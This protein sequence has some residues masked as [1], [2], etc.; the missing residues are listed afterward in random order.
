MQPKNSTSQPSSHVRTTVRLPL[1]V[2]LIPGAGLTPGDLGQAHSQPDADAREASPALQNRLASSPDSD[3]E[4]DFFETPNFF[5]PLLQSLHSELMTLRP[6]LAAR[7][8]DI[9]E[10]FRALE[11]AK[12]E[13]SAI[14]KS[15]SNIVDLLNL[16]IGLSLF[17]HYLEEALHATDPDMR[18]DPASLSLPQIHAMCRGLA[19]CAPS[20]GSLLGQSLDLKKE[21]ACLQGLTDTL[22]FQA[23]VLGLP[24]AAPANGLLLDILGWVGRG[25]QKGLLEPSHAITGCFELSLVLLEEWTGEDACRQL[26]TDHN[27]GRCAAT[28]ATIARYNAM[29]LD[30]VV[31]PGLSDSRELSNR[32]RLQHC[33]LNLCAKEVL[34]PPSASTIDAQSVLPVCRTIK[35]MLDRSLLP[36][37]HPAVLKKLNRLLKHIGN[38][39]DHALLGP[40]RDCTT[41]LSFCNFLRVLGHHR[42]GG[43]LVFR[44]ALPMQDFA[45]TRLIGCING[46][47]FEKTGRPSQTLAGLLGF[48]QFCDQRHAYHS[49]NQKTAVTTAGTTRST[50]SSATVPLGYAELE[51]ATSRLMEDLIAKG[52][53]YFDTTKAIGG[54]LLRLAYLSENIFL[55]ASAANRK[56]IAALIA[57]INETRPGAWSDSAKTVVLNA[58]QALLKMKIVRF[59]DVLPALVYLLPRATRGA[60]GKTTIEL[61]RDIPQLSAVEAALAEAME[62]AVDA[63]AAELSEFGVDFGMGEGMQFRLNEAADN[64]EDEAMEEAT[65]ILKSAP[66]TRTWPMPDLL[67]LNDASRGGTTIPV[68]TVIKRPPEQTTPMPTPMPAFPAALAASRSGPTS[69]SHASST[70]NA[71]MPTTH[72]ELDKASTA[73]RTPPSTMPSVGRIG[74]RHAKS[75]KKNRMTS[76]QGVRATPVGTLNRSPVSALSQAIA[77]GEPYELRLLMNQQAAWPDSA[78]AT[79]LDE[80]MRGR[81]TVDK[82]ILA[83]LK[84]FFDGI[85]RARGETG[86]A[87]LKQYFA[88]HPPEFNGLDALLVKA[89]L[90]LAMPDLKSDPQ[91]LASTEKMVEFLAY[92][93]D[94]AFTQFLSEKTASTLLRAQNRN[95]QNVLHLAASQNLPRV[96]ER[97][98]KRANGAPLL[99]QKSSYG[100]TP[101]AYAAHFGN[102]QVVRALLDHPTAVEQ[103]STVCKGG[104][105]ALMLAAQ[106]GHATVVALLLALKSAS[107]Q[108]VALNNIGANAFMLAAQVGHE[109]VVE[110]MLKGPMATEQATTVLET[111]SNA[112]VLAVQSNNEKVVD[113]LLS[114]SSAALQACALTRQGWNALMIAAQ[115]GYTEIARRL[116]AGAPA[117]EQALAA[118]NE[119]ANALMLAAWAGNSEV[120]ALLLAHPSAARQAA[121]VNASRRN[122]LMG[123]A[124]QGRMEALKLLLATDTATAQAA[125]VTDE[126]WNALALARRNAHYDIANLLETMSTRAD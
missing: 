34:E 54:L 18:L 55:P 125:A 59:D 20:N 30:A 93:T 35:D 94:K 29:D 16:Q 60:E 32:R 46:D 19:A 31:L 114:H 83:T 87:T 122:A 9:V 12:Y 57:G 25:L 73:A 53:G 68:I 21:R 36:A 41:L 103:A 23:M 117:E 56:F 6:P 26:L 99:Q 43:R 5:A 13:L 75:A 88:A 62:A 10:I 109:A 38:L 64:A 116:L 96:V 7:I 91:A 89:G 14:I 113:K 92:A 101:L 37:S 84:E 111:G 121:M 79:G 44:E 15:N 69:T 90:A 2:S 70:G 66:S 8:G 51:R 24:T 63:T 11:D 49:A 52:V 65:A 71:M 72:R 82:H 47:A 95:G 108:V 58:L 80:V 100:L 50:T 48:V 78:I 33:V 40:R 4:V 42:V 45:C 118:N 85:L 61:A 112:L 126:G 76:K 77:K 123:A 115:K 105:I 27:L 102:D 120:V 124:G 110:L 104:G 3:N 97:V 17:L 86:R 1:Q 119:K 106:N 67:A 81:T 39:P 22:L 74:K 98:L 28:L 107:T